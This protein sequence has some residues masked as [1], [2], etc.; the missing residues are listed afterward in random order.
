M[1][2]ESFRRVSGD[3]GTAE[4]HNLHHL[5]PFPAFSATPTPSSAPSRSTRVESLTKSE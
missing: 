1:V 5:P 4:F 3:H 2:E